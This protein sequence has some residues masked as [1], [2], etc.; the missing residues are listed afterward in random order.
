MPIVTPSRSTDQRLTALRRANRI[1]VDRAAMKHGIKNGLVSAVGILL[2]PPEYAET[3]KVE[4]LLR[5]VPKFGVV[6]ARHTMRVC[7][8]SETKTVGGLSP[9]QRD[10]LVQ[11][12]RP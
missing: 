10:E 8:I 9:R 5:A 12:L 3:M 7:R 2:D 1:R 11:E 4:A 6:K